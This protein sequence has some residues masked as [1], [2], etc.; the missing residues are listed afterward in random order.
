MNYKKICV[1][2]LS[3]A[4]YSSIK[5]VILEIRRNKK[6]KLQLVIGASALSDK[7]G[8]IENQV[9][10]DGFKID[11]KVNVNI[12]G[13]NPKEMPQAVGVSLVELP[14]IFEKLNPHLVVTI[15]DRYET[16]ST[17]IAATYMNI[18]VAHTMGGEITGTIDESIRHA[19]T[20]LSHIHFVSNKNSKDRV[21]KL[22]EN[23]KLVFNVG[24]PRIDE[25]KKILKKYNKKYVFNQLNKQG[26]GAKIKENEKFII[27]CNHPVTSEFSNNAKNIEILLRAVTK[28][29]LKCLTLWPNPDAGSDMISKKIR[30]F[31]ENNPNSKNFKFIKNLPLNIFIPLLDTA[32]CIIGNSSAGVRDCSFIGTRA[33]NIGSRQNK[34]LS[35]KNIVNIKNYNEKQI[36]REILN[37]IK[38]RKSKSEKIYGNGTAAKKIVKIILKLRN[39]KTQKTISY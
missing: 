4:N 15:G 8:S 32:K 21:I 16:I 5:S 37:Q 23:P 24:C 1:V 35:G 20:K 30:Q 19:I 36:T 34:R 18:P 11:Y 14:N 27:L 26:V 10:K 6:L 2:V 31:R 25:I 3:R 39:I 7:F 22:G 38:K 29:G 13:S 33:I 9:E 17:V 12:N 28:T